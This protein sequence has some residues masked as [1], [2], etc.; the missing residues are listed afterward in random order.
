VLR[1]F[2]EAAGVD[3]A[4]WRVLSRFALISDF[5]QRSFGR[6]PTQQDA[7]QGSKKVLRMQLIMYSIM[8]AMLASGVWLIADVFMIAFAAAIYVMF[9]VGTSVL[10]DH[11][12]TLTSTT[13][14]AVL[15]FRPVS[16][17]TYFAA[18]LTNILF[19][20]TFLTTA[21]VYL[22]VIAFFIKHGI[23]VGLASIAAAYGASFFAA[24]SLLLGYV[25][26]LRLVSADALKN[27]LSVFQLGLGFLV[28]GGYFLAMRFI[29]TDAVRSM[30]L[31]KTW[32]LMALP[33]AWF[34]SYVD[35]AR[36]ITSLNVWLPVVISAAGLALMVRLFLGRLSSEFSSRLSDVSIAG[37]RSSAPTTRTGPGRGWWF[38]EGERRAM[39][40]LIRSQFRNDQKF[41]MGVL[42]ILPLTVLYVFMGLNEG[43]VRNPFAAGAGRGNFSLVTFAVLMFPTML[44]AQLRQSDS[45]RASWL[46]FSA[47]ASRAR[48]VRASKNVVAATFLLPYL[49]V[50]A[51][52]FL[53][54]WGNILHVAIHICI[55]GLMSHLVLQVAVF[56]DPSIPF[57]EPTQKNANASKIFGWMIGIVFI[58]FGLQMVSVTLYRR[59][60]G[61]AIFVAAVVLVSVFIEMLTMARVEERTRKL[62][63]LG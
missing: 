28:Y 59:P 51:G 13:D 33:P 11:G 50:L 35:L 37:G 30:S 42:G 49:A 31:P 16:S 2:V 57:S 20:T 8:G 36:G 29:S 45:F 39:S 15:G 55:L 21:L 17:R 53:Y 14:Y 47:P 43:G 40:L 41:R 24:F 4:Q 63:F 19:Y 46:F 12:A 27:V 26:M 56:L 7:T 48:L 60:L 44:K 10:V 32:W 1:R 58:N 54:L 38:R 62:E 22:P 18:R 5:R 25:W 34:A 52:I 61:L 6:A 23:L 9:V 3:Y